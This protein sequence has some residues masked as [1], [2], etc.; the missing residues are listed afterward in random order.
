MAQ[1]LRKHGETLHFEVQGAL[2]V[3]ASM[4]YFSV[5]AIALPT[6]TNAQDTFHYD[7][8]KQ[9]HENEVGFRMKVT[10]TDAPSSPFAK[11]QATR[12][13]LHSRLV[14][15]DLARVDAIGKHVH[16]RR[17]HSSKAA[18]PEAGASL[19]DPVKSGLNSGTGEYF[20][21]LQVCSV[22]SCNFLS[23]C[24]AVA[25]WIA[26]TLAS[27]YMAVASLFS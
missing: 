20:V 6:S 17:H 2:V 1:L 23:K 24:I 10:H 26:D 19:K 7:V 21:T 11:R 3:V 12:A 5:F 8:S 16:K 13:E 27:E 25:N 4:M 15:R 14:E 22:I 9:V 18:T